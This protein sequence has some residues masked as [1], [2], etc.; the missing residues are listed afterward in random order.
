MY[1]YNAKLH[2][3]EFSLYDFCQY[4]LGKLSVL[5]SNPAFGYMTMVYLKKYFSKL[6]WKKAWSHMLCSEY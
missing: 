1:F 5:L 4:S 3:L 6:L 2:D